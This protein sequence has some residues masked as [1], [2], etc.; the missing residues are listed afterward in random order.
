MKCS[1]K[2]DMFDFKC[3]VSCLRSLVMEKF[4]EAF[5]TL[6][7]DD[8]TKMPLIYYKFYLGSFRFCPL[9]NEVD[10]IF[11]DFETFI[12]RYKNTDEG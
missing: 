8:T 10:H 2:R 12:I 6:G 5:E 7:V 1:K 4:G 3:F 11:R 9:A